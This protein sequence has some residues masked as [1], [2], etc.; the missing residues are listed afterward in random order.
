MSD[1]ATPV[2][3]REEDLVEAID[4]AEDRLDRAEDR[5][6][7]F[8]RE[9]LEELA[10]AYRRFTSLLERYEEKVLPDGG[11]RRTIIEF[12]SEIA[13]FSSSL[14][15]DMLLYGTFQECDEHLQQKWFN[16]SHFEYVREQLEPVADLVERLEEHEAA[17]DSY[18]K[19]RRE[20]RHEIRTLEERIDELERLSRLGEAD[21]DA[22]TER[23]REPIETYNDAVTTAFD[24]FLHEASA[25]EVVDF[26]DAMTAYPLVEFRE[27]P[28][29]LRQYLREEP[30]GEEH[31]STLLEYAG[32]SR[33]KLDH[34][35]DDPGR[36]TH[37]IGSR[38]ASLSGLDADPLTIGWPPP[39]AA[40]LEWR[41]QELTAAVN[42]FAPPVVEQ[43]RAVAT[44]PRETDY[45]RLRDST[46]ANE[47]LSADER[48]HLA[49][50]DIE[51]ELAQTRNELERLRN[52]LEGYP[53]R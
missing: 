16:E 32:Y 2:S 43:L 30:P 27:P 35:V 39:S 34:Y 37:V 19:T 41:C 52:A 29:K 50:R 36:L 22:P 13:E 40:E 10:D 3:G 51:A 53:K 11:D 8:G 46:R 12:Q 25:R 31:L 21:L 20:I 1:T 45:E 18:R 49:S 5:V 26:L 47:Q 9:Q 14:S 33:S 28:A 44:L 23:L 4:S 24:E 6:D 38:K 48:D 7:E 42:R 15:D 17:L